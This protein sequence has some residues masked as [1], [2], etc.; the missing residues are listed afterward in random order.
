MNTKK[1]Y[2]KPHISELMVNCTKSKNVFKNESPGHPTGT[3]G[4]P[5]TS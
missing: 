1:K 4:G 5:S 2:E 3:S